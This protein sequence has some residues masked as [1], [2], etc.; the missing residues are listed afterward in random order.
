[1]RYLVDANVLLCL[2]QLND[3]NYG[4]VRQA[5]RTLLARRDE[6]CCS[7]QN[8]VEFWNVHGITHVLTL[9]GADF[10]RYRG[11]T[12]VLPEDVQPIEEK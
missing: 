3:P 5:V 7:P 4:T 12:S 11:I 6:L 8:I 9:N 10:S 1:M 2:L